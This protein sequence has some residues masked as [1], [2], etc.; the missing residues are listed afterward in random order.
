MEPVFYPGAFLALFFA[1]TS[2]A[3]GNLVG[4]MD[5]DVIDSACV[6]VDVLAEVFHAHGRTFD[7]PARIAP[8]PR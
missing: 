2:F 3:L 5:R 1:K 4:V 7:V 8:S 6:D